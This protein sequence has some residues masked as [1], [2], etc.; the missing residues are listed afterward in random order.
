MNEANTPNEQAGIGSSESEVTKVECPFET[1][2]P[3]SDED[4]GMFKDREIQK[5]VLHSPK[6]VAKLL[7]AKSTVEDPTE[8]E[9]PDKEESLD[10]II[11]PDSQVS[12]VEMIIDSDDD[13]PLI[14][15]PHWESEESQ[16]K[17]DDV[18]KVKELEIEQDWIAEP[19]KDQQAAVSSEFQKML[20]LNKKL[21]SA[22][23]NLF[24]Q[25]EELKSTL[26]DTYKNLEKQK[27][28]SSVAE[29][30]LKQ[31]DRELVAA[32]E[33]T[34][35]LFDKLE[36]SLKN[37]QRQESLIES[38]K[39]H[40]DISQKRLAQ[41]ERECTRL[42]SESNEQSHK[43]L[44]SENT[45]QEL[46]TRLMRQQRQ[47]LQ[48]KAALEKCLDVS[49]PGDDARNKNNVNQN[50]SDDAVTS[51]RS[52]GTW[53]ST[54]KD[55]ERMETST[56]SKSSAYTQKLRSIL[57]NAQPIKPWSADEEFFCGDE[58]EYDNSGK[59]SFQPPNSQTDNQVDYEERIVEKI[60]SFTESEFSDH[61]QQEPV[62]Q[63]LKSDFQSEK[64]STVNNNS[65]EDLS[66]V[67]SANLSELEE[68]LDKTIRM[69]F[70]SDNQDSDCAST[71]AQIKSQLGNEQHDSPVWEAFATTV[72]EE[73]ENKSETVDN[74]EK[75]KNPVAENQTIEDSPSPVIY[76]H[77]QPKG[78]KSLASVELPN[79]PKKKDKD[80]KESQKESQKGKQKGK[81]K[82]Q[83]KNP[84]N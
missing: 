20:A 44:Q 82:D 18:D 7:P 22:N 28:R 30:M 37:I 75:E 67:E 53:V 19:D 51:T 23:D 40:L 15:S 5:A 83:K 55:D 54:P 25:V 77:R 35:S 39:S 36:A 59:E 34:K 73:S 70:T 84:G 2:A 29:S 38:Y 31:Q 41:L 69:F 45:C 78:R 33:Q 74:S 12:E 81:Q 47:T 80:T 4:V 61:N 48:F 46:R 58:E 76:P 3:G 63:E 11:E 1:F 57:K 9:Q 26:A 60:Y 17:S 66:S 71:S 24:A 52:D 64:S 79:F 56:K 65:K 8:I 72:E 68:Q 16:L 62:S 27:K 32:Q 10:W 42:Q 14:D 6:T 50:S 21:R 43:L 13:N 49:V